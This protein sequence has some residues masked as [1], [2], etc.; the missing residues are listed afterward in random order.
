M[1]QWIEIWHTQKRI[2][3]KN[4]YM[5]IAQQKDCWPFQTKVMN[6]FLGHAEHEWPLAK[7]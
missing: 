7:L 4:Y 5:K 2:G 3:I 1:K 6:I